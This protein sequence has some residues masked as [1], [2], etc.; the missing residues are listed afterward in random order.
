MKKLAT[1]LIIIII[2]SSV[3]L[4][5]ILY[6][7]IGDSFNEKQLQILYVLLII[8]GISVLY[9]FI[10]G[11][12][13]KNNSQMDKLWS[14]LPAIY[15]WVIAGMGGMKP[16]VVVMAILATI[17]GIRLTYN[18]AKKGAY[19]LKFW[20]GEEDYRWK[21]LRQNKI[22]KNRFVWAL[23]NLLFI[24]LYQNLLVLL[25]VIPA[26]YAVSGDTLFNGIDVL[27]TIMVLF[28]I[29]YEGIADS[30]QWKFQ[31]KKWDMINSGMKLEDLPYPY[32]L[33]FNTFGLWNISRHPNYFAEQMVWVSFYIFSIAAGGAI[34]NYSAIGALLLILLFVGSSNF[35]EKISSSK[36]PEYEKYIDNVSKFI[37]FRRFRKEDKEKIEATN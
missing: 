14:I 24:S 26:L 15:A 30:Q 33:G 2:L 20:Q 35:A 10:V 28:F 32:N 36:Y 37:P 19:S 1:I 4:C 27:A 34:F 21:I 7:K 11:E 23:F 12:I 9:C 3:I 16:R 18:F 6:Y 31:T 5:P 25:T 8:M 17:W 22:L 29:F 13:T